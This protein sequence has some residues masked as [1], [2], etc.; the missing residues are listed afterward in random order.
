[1]KLPRELPFII[2]DGPSEEQP[3]AKVTEDFIESIV[4]D[5]A[6]VC[7]KYSREDCVEDAEICAQLILAR[8]GLDK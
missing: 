1:M 7:I 3:Y 8:Y 4:R 2:L 6:A 5:C